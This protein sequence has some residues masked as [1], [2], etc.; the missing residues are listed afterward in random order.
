MNNDSS[1]RLLCTLGDA[2]EQSP[3]ILFSNVSKMQWH[4]N[5]FVAILMN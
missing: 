4:P 1:D 5:F 2:K 3:K